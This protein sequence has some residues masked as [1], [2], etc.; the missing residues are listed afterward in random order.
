VREAFARFDQVLGVM[1]MRKAEDAQPP[2]PVAE[3]EQI[4]EARREARRRRDFAEADRIRQDLD[5]RG[6]VLEDSTTGTRWKR[7]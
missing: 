5:A 3:I 2:V 4:I 7:K 6:I 1:V